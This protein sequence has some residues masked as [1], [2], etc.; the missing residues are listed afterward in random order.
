VLPRRLDPAN[1]AAEAPAK[2]S[3]DEKASAIFS[4]KTQWRPRNSL[5]G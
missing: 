1:A 5:R 4:M 3:L 2:M